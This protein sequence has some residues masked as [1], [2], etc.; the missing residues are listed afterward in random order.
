MKMLYTALL[1]ST[2]T[3]SVSH[4]VSSKLNTLC[5]TLNTPIF[6]F[7]IRTHIPIFTKQ[8]TTRTK[9]KKAEQNYT[10]DMSYP[11]P[12]NCTIHTT[13]TWSFSFL[14]IHSSQQ[15]TNQYSLEKSPFS[16]ALPAQVQCH[17]VQTTTAK[18]Y[19]PPMPSIASSTL[20]QNQ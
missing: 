14:S 11:F 13:L 12:S 17:P 18:P 19:P 20:V 7:P 3:I 9:K 2:V 1:T 6:Q 10:L 16:P 5:T 15:T 4:I 8:S